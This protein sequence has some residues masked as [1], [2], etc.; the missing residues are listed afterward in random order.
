MILVVQLTYL[1]EKSIELVIPKARQRLLNYSDIPLEHPAG[2]LIKL[3]SRQCLPH[4]CCRSIQIHKDRS[5][6]IFHPYSWEWPQQ[7][8]LEL[9]HQNYMKSTKKHSYMRVF[10]CIVLAESLGTDIVFWMSEYFPFNGINDYNLETTETTCKCIALAPYNMWHMSPITALARSVIKNNS[11][12]FLRNLQCFCFKW[13]EKNLYL[14]WRQ[15]ADVHSSML[16]S[17][18][19]PVKPSGHKQWYRLGPSIHLPLFWH[20]FETHSLMLTSHHAP[21]KWSTF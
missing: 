12:P 11:M 6:N 8:G 14:P 20:G 5:M 16:V 7:M 17:Q 3:N 18:W 21:R 15:C 4:I 2:L 13:Q 10:S 1:V 9:T 19:S